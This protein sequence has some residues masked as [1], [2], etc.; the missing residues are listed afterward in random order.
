MKDGQP[1]AECGPSA[2]PARGDRLS[3]TGEVNGGSQADDRKGGESDHREDIGLVPR[4]EVGDPARYYERQATAA[5][6]LKKASPLF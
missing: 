1:P 4:G 2:A 6:S 5:D 3:A